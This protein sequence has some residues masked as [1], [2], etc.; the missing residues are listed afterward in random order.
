MANKVTILFALAFLL[1]TSTVNGQDGNYNFNVQTLGGYTTPGVIPFWL[2]S[3]QYGSI[4]LDEASLS[5]IGSARK[6]YDFSKDNLFDWGASFEGRANLGQGSNLT[7]IEGYGKIRLS[8]FEFR[9]GRSKDLMGLCDTTLSSGSL[10]VSGNYLGIPKVEIYVSEFF[11]IPILGQLLAFK[12]N[13]SHGWLGEVWMMQSWNRRDSVLANTYLHQSSFYGRLGNPEWKFKLYGG[14]N[15]QAVWCNGQDFYNDDFTLS[16]LSTYLYVITGKRYSN[17]S[18]QSERLGNH[19]G[20]IDIGFEYKFKKVKLFLYRQNFY[21]TGALAY[22]ANIQDGLNGIS[23]EKMQNRTKSVSW[24]KLL[25]EFLYTKSQ[26]GAP[27]SPSSP[28]GSE[29]Y[30]NHGQY[31]NGW[32]Y[33]GIGLGTPFITARTDTREELPSYPTQYFINNRL[34]AFH[35]GG[36]GSVEDLNYTIKASWSRNYGTYLTGNEVLEAG[37]PNAGA[38]GIFG[39]QDQFST[40]LELGRELRNGLNLGCIA[41][42]DYGEL[43]YNS[44]GIFIKASYSL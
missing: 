23:V 19:L 20:S 9:A 15:H 31:I 28:S 41:A 8:I 2:R 18:I 13:F 36:E 26:G 44:F 22:L 37:I 10:A 30:Y 24:N 42:F 29:S 7:L 12:G 43:L 40:Y 11:I 5:L 3:N 34:L 33:G 32:S 39:E 1:V 38:Y 6:D 21:E 27:W 16:F 4:P 17:G 14:F 25:F 35:I